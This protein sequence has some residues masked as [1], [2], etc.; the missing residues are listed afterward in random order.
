MI[1]LAYTIGFIVYSLA[2]VLSYSDRLKNTSWVFFSLGLVLAVIANVL[3]LWIA[4]TTQIPSELYIRALVWDSMIVGTYTLV[5]IMMLGVRLSST[6][7]IGIFI[8]IVGIAI[9]KLSQ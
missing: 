1:T 8:I 2:V 5:P 3:W 7:I 6:A 4:R 9:T